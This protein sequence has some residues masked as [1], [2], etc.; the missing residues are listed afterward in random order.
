MPRRRVQ[1]FKGNGKDV[2]VVQELMRH[3]NV[4]LHTYVQAITQ[5]K[6]DAQSR[7]VSLL[8]DK[9]EE[10]PSTEAYRTVT[11]LQNSGGDW[12]FVEKIGVPDGI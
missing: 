1:Y 12:Q 9:N 10:K 8:L 4:T 5:S 3:A 11:D 7:V 2:Q 6:R